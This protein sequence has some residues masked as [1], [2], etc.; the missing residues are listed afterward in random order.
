MKKKTKTNHMRR[1]IGVC[2]THG[3]HNQNRIWIY[4]HVCMVIHELIC[5][6]CSLIVALIKFS[7]WAYVSVCLYDVERFNQIIKVQKQI[8]HY[9]RETFF[10][11]RE[12]HVPRYT[13]T[14]TLCTYVSVYVFC[15][16][17]LI[18]KKTLPQLEKKAI[19][20]KCYFSICNRF[21]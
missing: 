8:Q 13:R 16:R 11:Q 17:N 21:N 15:D 14:H 4:R 3:S 12:K 5:W 9:V 10:Y 19:R 18:R 1:S 6:I 20:E 2:E 7:W